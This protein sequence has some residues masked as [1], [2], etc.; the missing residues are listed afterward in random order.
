MKN[1][2]TKAKIEVIE[3]VEKE[4]NDEEHKKAVYDMDYSA[5]QGYSYIKT[6]LTRFLDNLKKEIK[7]GDEK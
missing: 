1:K 4:L 5:P 6:V 7:G 3:R 2:T